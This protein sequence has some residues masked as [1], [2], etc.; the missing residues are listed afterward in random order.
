MIEEHIS[1]VWKVLSG[2]PVEVFDEEAKKVWHSSLWELTS[3]RLEGTFA[4][5]RVIGAGN[6]VTAYNLLQ[7]KLITEDI[8]VDSLDYFAKTL[9]EL[10]NRKLIRKRPERVRETFKAVK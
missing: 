3:A 4:G 8:K 1:L 7:T 6:I 9:E 10:S 2:I 5:Q